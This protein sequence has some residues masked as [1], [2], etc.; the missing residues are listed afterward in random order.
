MKIQSFEDY[1]T[2]DTVLIFYQEGHGNTR[3]VINLLN[4]ISY[5]V[6]LGQKIPPEAMIRLPWALVPAIKRALLEWLNGQGM[7]TTQEATL[8]GTMESMK[9]H[10]EDL[11]FIL[12]LPEPPKKAEK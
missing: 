8:K 5:A 6:E 1:G 9:Y 3:T 4:G 11:R 12:K 7:E 2:G 10:L